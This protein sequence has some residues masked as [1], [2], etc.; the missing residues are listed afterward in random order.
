MADAEKGKRYLAAALAAVA[1]GL[2][3]FYHSTLD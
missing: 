1:Q 3:D 2:Q